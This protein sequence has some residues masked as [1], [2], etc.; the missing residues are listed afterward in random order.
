MTGQNQTAQLQRRGS[1]QDG[2]TESLWE[3]LQAAREMDA[4]GGGG[5]LEM[6]CSPTPHRNLQGTEEYDRDLRWVWESWGEG[7]TLRVAR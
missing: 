3:A 1:S 4:G 5:S 2:R 6:I 7:P